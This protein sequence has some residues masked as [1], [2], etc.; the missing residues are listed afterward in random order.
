MGRFF[1]FCVFFCAAALVGCRPATT[2]DEGGGVFCDDDTSLYGTSDPNCATLTDADQDGFP[3]TNTVFA[4][5]CNSCVTD[6]NDGDADIHPSDDDGNVP[7]DPA[8]DGIDQDCNG[9]DGSGF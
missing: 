9:V 4:C 1:C 2:G 5:C 3:A 8:G 6:C 7:A